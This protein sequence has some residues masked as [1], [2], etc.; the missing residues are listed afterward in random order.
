MNGSLAARRRSSSSSARWST[1]RASCFEQ[2]TVDAITRLD[3]GAYLYELSERSKAKRWALPVFRPRTGIEL[4]LEGGDY[5]VQP[6]SWS[7]VYHVLQRA[8]ASVAVSRFSDVFNAQ[9]RWEPAAR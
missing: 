6:T 8:G 1:T 4:L 3:T 5:P 2:R 7:A 9:G